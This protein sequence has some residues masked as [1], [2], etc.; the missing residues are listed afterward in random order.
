[1]GRTGDD[2]LAPDSASTV[3]RVVA[4]LRRALFEGELDWGTPL[5]EVSLAA[6]MGVSR[7]TVREALAQLVA[8]GLAVREPHRGVSV[9]NPDVEMVHDVC[10]GRLALEGAGVRAWVTAAEPLRAEVRRRLADYTGAVAR[11]ADYALL[12]EL[13]L[14]FHVSL[15]GLTGSPRLVAMQRSLV[16]ELRL[17]LAQVDRIR[18]NAH[19]QADSHTALVRLLESGDIEAAHRFL[20]A[21]LADAETAICDALRL[22]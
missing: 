17:A 5:R 20:V 15:V 22:V 8:D 16:G 7:P 1:M 14:E 21:H 2:V 9:A 12:T 11:G 6:S 3:H 4:E 19:A 13:H 18:R 10:L